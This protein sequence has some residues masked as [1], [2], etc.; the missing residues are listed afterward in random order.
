MGRD[1]RMGRIEK[2][3]KDD[4]FASLLTHVANSLVDGLFE[5]EY[6]QNLLQALLLTDTLRLM[7]KQ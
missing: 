6:R 1:P 3:F 7:G 2:A 4:H 5:K